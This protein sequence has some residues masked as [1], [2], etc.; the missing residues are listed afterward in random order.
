MVF[1]KDRSL[2]DRIREEY[3]GMGKECREW[4]VEG[5]FGDEVIMVEG[6]L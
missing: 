2:L 1:L 4:R 6:F 3:L 5:K